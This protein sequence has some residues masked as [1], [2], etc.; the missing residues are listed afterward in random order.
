MKET[1]TVEKALSSGRRKL[2]YIPI[3]AAFSFII[4][5]FLLFYLKFFDAWIIALGFILGPLSGWLIWSYNINKWKIWAFENVRNVHTLQR[6]A[7][8]RST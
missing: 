1:V 4:G 5:G 6:K 2:K 3:I 7:S 8:F